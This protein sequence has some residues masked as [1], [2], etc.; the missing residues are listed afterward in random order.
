MADVFSSSLIV[1]NDF[2]R[3]LKKIED[4]T[5][6]PDLNAQTFEILGSK[7]NMSDG[8]LGLTLVTEDPQNITY[9][10]YYRPLA[11]KTLYVMDVSSW[12]IGFQ[13]QP[14]KVIEQGELLKEQALG[15]DY[16]PSEKTIFFGLTTS[17]GIGC[18]NIKDSNYNVVCVQLK[19][20][21]AKFIKLFD[22]K[23]Y[24]IIL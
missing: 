23:D 13:P 10:L 18:W 5:F 4:P 22:I 16:S 14:R 1:Y 12:K 3:S 19:M 20:Q 7:W 9:S 21:M 6:K 17:T 2:D 11:S 8:L 24:L 15:Q